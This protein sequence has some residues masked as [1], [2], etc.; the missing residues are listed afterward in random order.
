MS[1]VSSWQNWHV[2]DCAITGI[3]MYSMSSDQRLKDHGFTSDWLVL[4]KSL[5]QMRFEKEHQNDNEKVF[6]NLSLRA[7]PFPI[8]SCCAM[9]RALQVPDS[10]GTIG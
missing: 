3:L 5:N 7:P 4:S 1:A 6:E 2:R 8:S 9:S 10:N